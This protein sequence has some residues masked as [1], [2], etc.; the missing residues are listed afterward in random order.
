MSRNFN[1][2]GFPAAHS[3]VGDQ[4]IGNDLPVDEFPDEFLNLKEVFRQLIDADIVLKGERNLCRDF[5]LCLQLQEFLQPFACRRRSV[6]P[7][8]L[9]AS[10]LD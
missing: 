9:E 6:R 10:L 8:N 2:I 7:K 5:L 1:E 3:E 4:F